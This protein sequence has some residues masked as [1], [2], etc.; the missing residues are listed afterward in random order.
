MANESNQDT[1]QQSQTPTPGFE[2]INLYKTIAQKVADD[3][4]LFNELFDKLGKQGLLTESFY[5]EKD[6]S[7]IRQD[8]DPFSLFSLFNYDNDKRKT[9]LKVIIETINKESKDDITT[10]ILTT[11]FSGIPH[12]RKTNLFFPDHSAAPK[13]NEEKELIKKL[14]TLCNAAVKYNPDEDQNTTNTQAFLNAFNDV[15]QLYGPSW[16]TTTMVLFAMRPDAFLP[17]DENT[18]AYLGKMI[19]SIETW[20]DG[21]DEGGKKK[22]PYAAVLK[23]NSAKPPTAKQYLA[24]M[25]AARDSDSIRKDLGETCPPGEFFAKISDKAWTSDEDNVKTPSSGRNLETD[26][27]QWLVDRGMNKAESEGKR[28]SDSA[29]NYV[30]KIKSL[31][32]WIKELT[33]NEPKVGVFEV[34]GLRQFLDEYGVAISM[35]AFERDKKLLKARLQQLDPYNNFTSFGKV[36]DYLHESPPKGDRGT[37]RNSFVKYLE[38]LCELVSKGKFPLDDGEVARLNIPLSELK[39]ENGP[40][41]RNLIYF[42]APGTGKSF[43]LKEAVEAKRDENGMPVEKGKNG[44]AIDYERVT[45]YP[46]YSYAQFVGCY[47]PVM[48]GRS[49]S[50]EDISA[51]SSIRG[52]TIDELAQKLRQIYDASE[53]GEP[54][55]TAAVLLFAEQYIDALNAHGKGI[56][57]KVVE[58]AGL[59]ASAYSSWLSAGIR[60]ATFRARQNTKTAAEEIAYKFVPGPF[61]RILVQALNDHGN[62]YCLVIEEINRANAAAVFGDVFQLLDRDREGWS[63][64]EVAASEDVKKFLLDVPEKGGLNDEGK[65][66]LG[67]KGGEKEPLTLKIPSNMY[68]WATMNSADQGVFPMDTAFKRR[69]EFEYVDINNGKDDCQDWT[70]GNTN[71]KWNDFRTAINNLLSENGVNEDKLM[72]A[73]FVKAQENNGTKTVPETA[74][75]SKVLM[76]LWEDAARMCRKKIFIDDVSTFSGLITKWKGKDGNVAVFKLPDNVKNRLNMGSGEESPGA[77][78]GIDPEGNGVKSDS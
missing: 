3:H 45:F 75:E 18:R 65:K 23:K 56:V 41:P 43:K 44:T 1:Q 10:D 12:V 50:G 66:A 63:E 36:F 57:K 49:A 27:K 31:A 77:G 5:Q 26:F 24:I 69:W 68:I 58:K 47:K 2:W 4:V 33:G 48:E 78:G 38:F 67:F 39:D 34:S 28:K 8:L 32:V 59:P 6:P 9:I 73:H 19:R 51:S 64:Y 25:K 70:I 22:I 40:L 71:I 54:G 21:T 52:L 72:G 13:Q 61:L 14:W 62:N 20:P 76:Y 29:G 7:R 42:G 37:T 16:F 35:A 60:L 74:F 46:T 15:K 30:S 11:K 17:L 53:S 55:Q